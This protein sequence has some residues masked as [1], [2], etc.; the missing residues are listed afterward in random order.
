VEEGEVRRG[1]EGGEVRRVS[2]INKNK[3]GM[4]VDARELKGVWL[5]EE[6]MQEKKRG[7]LQHSIRVILVIQR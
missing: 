3:R 2:E 5:Q 1:K 7:K 4:R 6:R